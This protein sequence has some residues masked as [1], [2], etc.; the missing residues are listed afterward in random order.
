MVQRPSDR[1]DPAHAAVVESGR[2]INL[3]NHT[4]RALIAMNAVA[5]VLMAN[6][7]GNDCGQPIVAGNIEGGLIDA[8]VCLSDYAAGEIEFFADRAH[9]EYDRQNKNEVSRG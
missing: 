2:A 8:L 3:L 7:I 4:F 6:G 1:I 5:K 9:N